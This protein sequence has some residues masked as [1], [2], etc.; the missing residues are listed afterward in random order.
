MIIAARQVAS[1]G[2]RYHFQEIVAGYGDQRIRKAVRDWCHLVKDVPLPMFHARPEDGG[3]GI[4]SLCG[5]IPRLRRDRID[6]LVKGANTGEDEALRWLV[7]H[8][9]SIKSELEKYREIRYRGEIVENRGDIDSISAS[10]LHRTVDGVGLKHGRKVKPQRIAGLWTAHARCPEETLSEQFSSGQTFCTHVA[11]L[12]EGDR[13]A[14]P[15]A[16]TATRLRVIGSHPSEVPV[17]PQ[18]THPMA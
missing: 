3:Y 1:A 14:K 10:E 9:P 13:N 16:N 6:S 18:R 5:Q 17:H 11:G 8:S 4:P 7:A 12:R 2:A 15:S